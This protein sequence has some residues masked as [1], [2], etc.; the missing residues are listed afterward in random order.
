MVLRGGR[1]VQNLGP[2]RFAIL[3][4]TFSVRCTVRRRG[5]FMKTKVSERTAPAPLRAL[6]PCVPSSA[7][8]YARADGGPVGM[9]V[10]GFSAS[11]KTRG[12]SYDLIDGAPCWRVSCRRRFLRKP[13][14][15]SPF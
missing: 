6:E 14:H 13:E 9:S 8:R 15:A 4:F 7:D 5:C 10:V 1:F 3:Y 2:V 11:R 12:P